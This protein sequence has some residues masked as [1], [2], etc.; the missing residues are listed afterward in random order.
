MITKHQ[1]HFTKEVN[2]KRILIE[3]DFDA[4][5]EEVWNAWTQADVLDTWWAPRPWKTETK[6]MDFR[7]GGRWLYVMAGPEGEQHW[8]LVDYK[9]IDPLKSF[10]AV[11]AFC[12]ENGN[13]ADDGTNWKNEFIKSGN[14]SKMKIELRF[15]TEEYMKK[16]TDM[17]FEGGFTM[18][19]GNLDEI[20]AK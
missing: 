13:K 6:S 12:D 5:V 20:L 17:G 1:T 10:T 19:L 14:G 2:K 8:C 3:R 16:I 7:A 11:D 4:P 15:S 18:A 9:T